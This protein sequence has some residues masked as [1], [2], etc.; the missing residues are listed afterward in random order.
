MAFK[1]QCLSESAIR[2]E[3]LSQLWRQGQSDGVLLLEEMGLLRGAYR[4]D[5]VAIDTEIAG[6]EIKSAADTLDRL[7]HQVAAY[8]AVFDRASL[9][10]TASHL[11]A[12]LGIVPEWWGLLLA[13][14]RNARTVLIEL[15]SSEANPSPDAN[16][17]VRMLWR[18]EIDKI[19]ADAGEPSTGRRDSACDVLA[20][21]MT[22]DELRNQ[23]ARALRLREDWLPAYIPVSCGD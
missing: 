6:Y 9:V 23:V 2:S 11:K 5:V 20:K 21:T 14:E 8:S 15:R 18:Q 17:L 19:L 1:R 7:P 4:A 12:A 16:A 10:V 3:L 13:T 22:W